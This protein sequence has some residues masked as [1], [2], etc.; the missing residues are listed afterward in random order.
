MQRTSHP[1]N[2]SDAERRHTKTA[3]RVAALGVVGLAAAS[4]LTGCSGMA[5]T[6]S[7][8]WNV[9]Y[10]ITADEGDLGGVTKIEYQTWAN[11]LDRDSTVKIPAKEGEAAGL[12]GSE[13]K[14]DVI[15]GAGLD[16]KL[17]A[18]GASVPLSCKIILEGKD[19]VAESTAEAGKPLECSATL[20]KFEKN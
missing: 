6:F 5:E 4:V 8:R 10:Q 3:L 13:W 14:E 7:D 11:T 1:S 2:P 9:Q 17:R 19:V 18:E 20:P 12:S 15:V 16:A